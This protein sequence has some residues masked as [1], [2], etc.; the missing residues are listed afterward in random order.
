MRKIGTIRTDQST[1]V[2]EVHMRGQRG[3]HWKL[4]VEDVRGEEICSEKD[5]GW[6]TE[7]FEQIIDTLVEKAPE[8]YQVTFTITLAR[9]EKSQTHPI[10]SILRRLSEED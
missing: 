1:Q 2:Q 9:K 5:F 6:N 4:S 8:A 10:L 7:V 3:E